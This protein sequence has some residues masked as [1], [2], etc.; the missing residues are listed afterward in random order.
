[1]KFCRQPNGK[2]LKYSSVSDT[3]EEINID[4]KQLL[5]EVI[6]DM[7]WTISDRYHK[8]LELPNGA[9][10]DDVLSLRPAS[11]KRKFS[12]KKWIEL[13]ARCGASGAQLKE[14]EGSIDSYISYLKEELE[15]LLNEQILNDE[16]ERAKEILERQIN[17]LS[18]KEEVE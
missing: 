3:I 15:D 1:M 4:E 17:G 2:F 16:G 8:L 5:E 9:Y 14:V 11:D 6:E 18:R 13:F 12:R 7:A 10:F